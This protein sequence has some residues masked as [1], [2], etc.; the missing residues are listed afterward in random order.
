MRE[1]GAYAES[2]GWSA[3]VHDPGPQVTFRREG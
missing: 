3:M 1:I 2:H